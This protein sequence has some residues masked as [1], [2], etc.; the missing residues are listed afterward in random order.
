MGPSA[1]NVH[2]SDITLLTS[3]DDINFGFLAIAFLRPGVL[4]SSI[5]GLKNILGKYI[6]ILSRVAYSALAPETMLSR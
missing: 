5:S 3:F 2:T 1:L 6:Q 4:T